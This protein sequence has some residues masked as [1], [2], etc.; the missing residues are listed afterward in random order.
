[1]IHPMTDQTPPGTLSRTPDPG[2]PSWARWAWLAGAAFLLAVV[3]LNQAEHY[4]SK[5]K[6][7]PAASITEVTPPGMEP[8]AM[9]ARLWVKFVVVL[10]VS[11][12]DRKTAMAQVAREAKTDIDAFRVALAAA[13][14]LDVPEAV[15]RLE[16][17]RA[18]LA[19]KETPPPGLAQ[20]IDDALRAYALGSQSLDPDARERLVARHGWFGRLLLVH[21]A[22]DSAGERAAV[23][24]GGWTLLIGFITFGIVVLVAGITGFVLFVVAIVWISGRRIR[25]AFE[26]PA[27]GG[28]VYL[29]AVAAFIGAFILFKVGSSLVIGLFASGGEMPAWATT[30]G[31][32]G[33]W[34][35][36]IL[37][38][39]PLLRGVAWREHALR[40]G[41][42]RGAGVL[43]EVGAGI[44]GYLAGLPIV[45]LALAI[46]MG[47]VLVRSAMQGPD[48]AP[49]KNPIVEIISGAGT[50][51]LVLLFLLATI[52]APL[53]EEA[54][55]RGAFY[56]HLRSRLGVLLS[57]GIS[58]IVF[59]VMHGYDALLLTPVISLGFVFALIREWRGSLIGPIVAHALHNATIMSVVL[60][61]FGQL[62]D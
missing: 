36:L 1:M 4:F 37:P 40:M 62:A 59:G 21:D 28:S 60:L 14:I 46:S 8:V 9:A 18:R 42:H 34:T 22:T 11:D 49:P 16:E 39:Y 2:S 33:Q 3:V 55:F 12:S 47:V 31:L 43:R 7:A 26:A 58:A 44:V 29:E 24:G 57:A 50:L 25:P 45:G 19:E 41:W 35:L 52:W 56:R 10:P 38:L 48:A 32:L 20:D 13:E 27:P 17:L 51:Q 5:D 15:T 30:A 61:V 23:V 6:P 53:V 54:V